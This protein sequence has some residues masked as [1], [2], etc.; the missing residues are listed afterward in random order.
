MKHRP[1]VSAD[2][3]CWSDVDENTMSYRREIRLRQVRVATLAYSAGFIVQDQQFH[4]A[5]GKKS[6]G[7]DTVDM[8]PSPLA[9]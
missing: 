2:K 1:M 3:V 9:H 6:T 8:I 7:D 5:W 4:Q